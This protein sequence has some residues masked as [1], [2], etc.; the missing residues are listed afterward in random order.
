[1]R[2]DHL[3]YHQI[4]QYMGVGLCDHVR[5]HLRPLVMMDYKVIES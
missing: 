3:N 2:A 5:I 1:M 4:V